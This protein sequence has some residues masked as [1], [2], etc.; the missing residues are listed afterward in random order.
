VKGSKRRRR[1]RRVMLRGASG[2]EVEEGHVEGEQ[3]EE[4]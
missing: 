3:A 1:R 4:K 2:G